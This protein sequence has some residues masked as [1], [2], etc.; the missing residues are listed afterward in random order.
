MKSDQNEPMRRLERLSRLGEYDVGRNEPD[1][2][3]WTVVNREGNAVGEVKDLLVDTDRMTVTHLDVE[4][5]TKTFDL[6][7][8]DPHV[9]VPVE[10]ARADGKRVVVDEISGNW[11]SEL[12]TARE[13]HQR[14][15]W[16]GWWHR[17][18]SR[19]D[20]PGIGARITRGVPRDDLNRV[21]DDVRPGEAV[22]IP[23]VEEEIVVERRPVMRDEL[24]VNRAAD[25]EPPR[26]G[27]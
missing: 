20:G 7:D 5:D 9:V 24:V 25:D 27:R 14:E 21:I 1:P 23:V 8:D 2:R 4:L 26:R 12:R 11:V 3:G 15:F 17:G 10:R 22:R 18:E 16:D 19:H 6:R 13:R